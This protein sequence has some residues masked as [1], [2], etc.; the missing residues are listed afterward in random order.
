VKLS[1]GPFRAAS[2]AYASSEM[3]MFRVPTRVHTNIRVPFAF[4]FCHPVHRQRHFPRNASKAVKGEY[5][6]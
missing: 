3:D 6:N 2:L 5:M 1:L 4:V